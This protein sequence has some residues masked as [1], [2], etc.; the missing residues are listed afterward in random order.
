M[1]DRYIRG[2]AAL[3]ITLESN[4]G[5][6]VDP[7]KVLPVEAG[8]GILKPSFDTV[9]MDPLSIHQG[10]KETIVVTEFATVEFEAAMKLPNDKD[11]VDELFKAS[12]LKREDVD[13]GAVYTYDSTTNQS[14]SFKQIA[15]R[16]ETKTAGARGDLKISCEAGGVASLSVGIKSSLVSK[17]RLG[18]DAADNAIPS[19]PSYEAVFMTKSCDAYLVNGKSVHLQKV[20]LALNAEITQPKSTCPMGAVGVDI[21]PQLSITIQDSLENE[22]G[23]EDIKNGTEF[24]FVIPLFDKAGNKKWEI[25][26]P[27][28]VAI[29]DNEPDSDGLLKLERTYECRKV[30]GDDNLE[31]R[32]FD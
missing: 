23:F 14:A 7:T 29:E 31:I 3:L 5:E 22:Q 27:K 28:C 10:S 25:V 13:G 4:N 20:E 2:G 30:D 19:T 18:S 17:T 9:D 26:A 16:V 12:G 1:A 21:K 8:M 11:L 24:N 32:Y 6:Y 15:S